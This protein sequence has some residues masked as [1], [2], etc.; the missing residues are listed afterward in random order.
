MTNIQQGSSRCWCHLVGIYLL[1]GITIYFL[2]KEFVVYAKHRHIYL[3]QRHAHLRTVLVEGIPHKMRSTVTL[4]MYFETLYPNAVLSVKVGQDLRYLDRLVEQRLNAVT[5][6]ERNLYA[7]HLGKKRPTVRVGNMMENVDAIRYYT[8]ILDDLNEVI[9]KEQESARRLA[10]YVDRISGTTAINVIEGFLKVTEIGSVKRF[11]KEKTGS[12]NKWLLRNK[13]GSGKDLNL[14]EKQPIIVDI[15]SVDTNI[16]RVNKTNYRS[17]DGTNYADDT[18]SDAKKTNF[19]LYKM[20]WTEWF[21]AMSSAPTWMDCWRVLK[22]GRN[23]EDHEHLNEEETALISPPEERRM[24]L[25]K[26]FVTFKTFTAA[27]T[28]RQVVHMQLAGHMAICEAPEP[29][30][31][32]WINLYSTRTGTFWRRFFV[33]VAVLLLFIVWVAPVTLISFVVSEDALRSYSPYIDEWCDQSLLIQSA[34]ELVQ[35]GALV[36]LMTLLPPVLSLLGIKEGCISFSSNQFRA[37]DRYFTFQ[38]INVFLVTTIAGSVID[39]IR[40]IYEDPSSTFS[41]LGTSLPKMGGFF[42]NYLIIKAFTGLGMEIMR[43]AAFFSGTLKLLFTSNVTVRDRSSQILFGSVRTM[44]NPGWFPFSK[45]IAQDI[46]LVVVCATYACI[47]P[48]IL[49][50]GLC[51]FF[52]A[53]LVYKHQNLFVYEPIYE[54]G[55]KWWPR[56][57]RCFVVALLFAQA[58]MVGMMILKQTYMEIYF[59]AAIIVSTGLYYWYLSQLYVPLAAQLPYDMATSMDLDQ[60]NFPDELAGA[61]QYVQP[62]LRAGTIKPEVEFPLTD[63]KLESTII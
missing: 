46:L 8:H 15:S 1:T 52:G 49:V 50:P 31:V 6:L 13:V 22:E 7:H 35:P 63:E 10:M 4:A 2:E 9:T 55:G 61:D 30:D 36:A 24:F 37:F 44:S 23:A 40:D 48:L 51:Y 17:F 29:T 39:C 25:S 5:Q 41:L 62:S 27:T 33:E 18:S 19:V 34:V 26:A 53:S 32:T 11:L 59:L 60:Q 42:T 43:L 28:A 47:A 12:S 16:K 38:I 58:T 21:W 57:A 54:T 45:V 56:M 20:T 14:S 3:R